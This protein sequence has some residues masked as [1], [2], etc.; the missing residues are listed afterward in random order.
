M[1][2]LTQRFRRFLLLPLLLLSAGASAEPF[3]IEDIRV[4]GLQRI[5]A[6]TV[7]NYLP[8]RIGDTV[9][10]YRSPEIIRALFRT[11]FFQDVRLER[12]GG[13]LIVSVRERPA[14]AKIDIS[15]NKSLE[16]ELLLTALKDI[17]LAEGRVL[18]RSVLDKIEQ[19]LRRQYFSQGKYAVQLK[20]AVTPLERNRV[21]VKIDIVEGETATIK[22]INITG[23][24]AFDDD[25]LL[26][27]FELST[28]GWLS[29][30]TKDDQYSRQK[31]SGDLETLRSFYL[32]RGHIN[33]KIESTQVSIT[34]D[35]EHIYVTVNVSEGDVYRISEIQLAGDLVVPEEELFPFIR[36]NRDDVFSRKAVIGSSDRISRHLGDQGYA[37]ANVNS[38]PEIDE[39][40]KTVSVTY[41]VDPGKRVYVRRINMTGNSVTRDEVLRREMRQMEAAWFSASEVRRSRARLQRLGYFE[42]VN[43]ETP[44]VP[45]STDEVDVNIDV[46]EKSMGN[47]TAGLGYSQ[48]Q[49]FIFNANIVQDNFL[50]TGKRVGFGFNNSKSNTFYQLAYNNPY[51]TIDGISRGW[52]LSYRETDFDEVDTARYL[53]DKGQAG[54][55]FG[56]PI[57]E[58]DR[59]RFDFDIFNIK[60]KVGL[61]ASD[62]IRE[63]EEQYGDKFLNYMMGLSWRRDSR[64]SALMPTS[65]GQQ[66]LGASVSVPGSDLSFYTLEYRNRQYFPIDDTFTFSLAADLAYGDGFGDT[67]ELPPWEKFF[68]GGTKSVR[69][70]KDYSLGPRDSTDDPLGGSVKLVAN[71]EIL[72][73]APFK[74]AEKT[75]R[76]GLFVDAGNVY[77]IDD[78]DVGEIRYS[79]GLSLFWLSPFGAL[80]L[81]YGY[82]LNDEPDDDIENFQ[83]TFGTAF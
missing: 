62:E 42:E 33:F 39:E 4:E 83:F 3:V 77:D 16:T 59:V 63:F 11:G 7:F 67:D 55:N 18:N 19:E 73:P 49:G 32:D 80:G 66:S 25:E 1:A 41:F 17:G 21:A 8:V 5:S 56:I 29:W 79:T 50:G 47:L 75:V 31:L 74:L 76:L 6:G 36:L 52:V 38:I 9:D 15:G 40:N 30:I 24:R 35:K 45:G 81:S 43:V 69:G 27:E 10:S 37:F 72:F 48:S 68:A 54:V 34:P 70:F 23:N 46:V 22:R 44:A 71:A 53:L 82:P 65:G 57:T 60:Y 58:T 51:Y 13:L 26:D 12:D 20:S 2:R 14:I 78:F 61:D 28:G 64:D